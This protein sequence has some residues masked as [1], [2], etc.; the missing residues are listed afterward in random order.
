M[1]WEIVQPDIKNSRVKMSNSHAA[2]KLLTTIL[3]TAPTAFAQST[4]R[5]RGTD[6]E[7]IAKA[8][9]TG[10][11]FITK[12]GRDHVRIHSR[13]AA[14]E[15]PIILDAE[16]G[17][18]QTHDDIVVHFAIS[19]RKAWDNVHQHCALVLPFRNKNEI[20]PWCHCHGMPQGEAVPLKQVADLAARWHGP[21]AE[22][23]WRKWT[24]EQA[25]TIFTE[26]GLTSPFW[27]LS[28][29]GIY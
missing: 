25:Q 20:E 28:G 1:Y 5:L 26:S 18:I 17:S 21:Y 7:K 2:M 11:A 24:V 19:P 16:N 6:A 13:I 15:M 10:P 4:N 23:S 22:R 9:R 29:T 8:Q 14:E 27:Q 3:L 12:D